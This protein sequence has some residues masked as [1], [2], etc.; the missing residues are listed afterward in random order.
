MIE[1]YYLGDLER[2]SEQ[3]DLYSFSGDTNINQD[4][5]REQQILLE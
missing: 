5:I 1:S 3:M 2:K 4:S